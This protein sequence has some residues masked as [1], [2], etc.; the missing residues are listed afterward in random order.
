MGMYRMS[1]NDWKQGD[2]AMLLQFR[3]KNYRSFA[4]EAVLDM[5]AS[6]ACRELPGFVLDGGVLP[7]AAI[8]GANASGKSNV[9]K[10]YDAFTTMLRDPYFL[11]DMKQTLVTP[12]ALDSRSSEPTEYEAFVRLDNV[13]YRYGF[14]ANKKAVLREWLSFKKNSK[15]AKKETTIFDRKEN[16][17]LPGERYSE[18]KQ[19]EGIV[20]ST[21][22]LLTLLGKKE[23]P[24][25]HDLFSFLAYASIFSSDLENLTNQTRLNTTAEQFKNDSKFKAYC[26]NIIKKFDP[27]ISSIMVKKELDKDQND[28]FRLFSVHSLPDGRKLS[29][30][31]EIESGGTQKLV[32]YLFFVAFCLEFGNVLAIDELDAQLHP[33]ILREL[34]SMFHD[35]DINTG[36]GQLIITTHNPILLDKDC[37]RRDEIW[38]TEKDKDG[39]SSLYSLADFRDEDEK[40]MRSDLNYMDNYLLGRFGA[41]PYKDA[42]E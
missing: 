36:K 25:T 38:F 7:V 41:I 40:R 33:L 13:E 22:L 16:L 4:D 19:F 1:T 2:R 30:P 37:L 11:K 28:L 18:I 39:K 34:I 8:Y 27:C 23:V 31:I 14:I 20:S 6:P 21:T 32:S 24:V 5:T 9:I 3:F 42:E 29:W 26:I 15:R 17:I 10:A 35:P 12:Y